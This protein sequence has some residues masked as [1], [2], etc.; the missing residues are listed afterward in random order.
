[1]TTTNEQTNP[2]AGNAAEN[3]R[4]LLAYYVKQR[5]PAR[6]RGLEAQKL[7]TETRAIA[8]PLFPQILPAIER[9]E[10]VLEALGKAATQWDFAANAYGGEADLHGL[11]MAMA[12]HE[13]RLDELNAQMAFLKECIKLAQIDSVLR[14]GDWKSAARQ[15]KVFARLETIA[16]VEKAFAALSEPG[17]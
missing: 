12:W 9:A 7:L 5:E 10:A 8:L 2:Q 1:M 14:Q 6:Q 15:R 13:H 4:K 16:K 11:A 17:E 3:G